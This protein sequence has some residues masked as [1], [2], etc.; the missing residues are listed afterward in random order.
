M[1]FKQT[2]KSLQTQEKNLNQQLK[3]KVQELENCKVIISK[4]Q[5]QRDKIL[6]QIK[7]I[8]NSGKI[9]VSEHAIIRYLERVKGMSISEIESEIINADVLNLIETLG[10]NGSYPNGTFKLIIKNGIVT[11]ITV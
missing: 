8:E 7:A 4:L 3:L 5:S 1:S 11:T 9:T 6:H 10:G 2:L